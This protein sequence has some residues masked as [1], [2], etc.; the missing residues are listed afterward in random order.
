MILWIGLDC[1]CTPSRQ[2]F[3][4]AYLDSP[5]PLYFVAY[6]ERGGTCPRSPSVHHVRIWTQVSIRHWLLKH[7]YGTGQYLIVIN[8]ACSVE[9]QTSNKELFWAKTLKF[10]SLGSA[11]SFDAKNKVGVERTNLFI[12]PSLLPCLYQKGDGPQISR[13]ASLRAWCFDD[14]RWSRFSHLLCC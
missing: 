1:L 9:F 8:C 13:T 14:Q 4:P 10:P 5:P 7:T 11:G 6:S 2:G 3:S 12:F